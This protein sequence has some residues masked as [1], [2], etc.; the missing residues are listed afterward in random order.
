V[1]GEAARY[2]PDVL[3]QAEGFV[4][5]HHAGKGTLAFRQGKEP[6]QPVLLTLERDRTCSMLPRTLT[7]EPA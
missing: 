3:V 4:D 2:V 7:D 5:H 6:G 1:G